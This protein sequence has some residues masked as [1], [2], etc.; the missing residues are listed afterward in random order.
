MILERGEP[1]LDLVKADG[2]RVHQRKQRGVERPDH[3]SVVGVNGALV[4][5]GELDLEALDDRRL[6][7]ANAG[8]AES[9]R[10]RCP[11]NRARC[12]AKKTMTKNGRWREREREREA[13]TCKKD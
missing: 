12:P 4:G 9:R 11:G 13:R 1:R 5:G 6:R 10:A 2:G 3:G 8:G 7:S